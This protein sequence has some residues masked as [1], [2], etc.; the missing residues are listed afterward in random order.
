[1][2]VTKGHCLCGQVTYEYRGPRKWAGHCHCESCRRNTSSAFTTWFGVPKEAHRF[3]GRAPA[4][5]ESSPGAKRYFCPNCGTPMAFESYRWPDEIHLYAASLENSRDFAPQ[6]HVNVVEKV[7]W[8]EIGDHLPQ[9]ER[10][11]S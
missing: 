7:P 4:V 1:M 9:Y 8:I 3:T 5:Y 11:A 2:D 6:F 10:S